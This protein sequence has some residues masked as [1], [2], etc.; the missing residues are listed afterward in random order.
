MSTQNPGRGGNIYQM[1]VAI[2]TLHNLEDDQK[3]QMPPIIIQNLPVYDPPLY[4]EVERPPQEKNN[5]K[6]K[7]RKLS[8]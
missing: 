5:N 3:A 4:I 2:K 6:E 8:K 7:K 1:I